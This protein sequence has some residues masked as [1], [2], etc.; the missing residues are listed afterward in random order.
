MGGTD[1]GGISARVLAAC[2]AAGFA[3]T[4]EVV[5]TSANSR[6]DALQQACA[7]DSAVTL[8]LDQP[9]LAGFFARHD[10][11]IGAGGGATWE[12]CCIGAP[13]V[14]MALV[15]NQSAVVPG[16]AAGHARAS[17][18]RKAPCRARTSIAAVWISTGPPQKVSCCG[19]LARCIW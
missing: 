5:S 4:I 16:L 3:G 18:A 7:V 10:L 13:T 1:P 8:T 11:Q 17:L 14:A 2:R 9:D 19:K 12:R 6:L 15:A